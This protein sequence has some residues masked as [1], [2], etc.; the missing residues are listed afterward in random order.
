VADQP[1][2]TISNV[3]TIAIGGVD[4]TNQLA[5]RVGACWVELGVNLPAAFHLTLRDANHL[6]TT[7]FPMIRLGAKIAVYAVADQQGEDTPLMTGAITGLET[8]YDGHTSTTVVRGLDHAFK[9]L[10]HRRTVG[11]KQMSATEIVT[12]LAAQDGVELGDVDPSGI[13]YKLITQPN[14]SD[15]QF[16]NELAERSGMVADFDNWGKLRFRKVEPAAEGIS[17]GA[18]PTLLDMKV[19]VRRCRTGITAADQVSEVEVRGWDPEKKEP[20]RAT[21]TGY[22][23][24]GLDIGYTP[25]QAVTAFGLTEQVE[26][27]TPYSSYAEVTQAAA[28]L[29]SDI[30]SSF[31][32]LEILAA[33][34][35]ELVPGKAVT[36]KNAGKP[37]DGKYTV[38]TAR[39]EFSAHNSYQT[40]IT[41][42]GRQVRNLYGLAARGWAS[43]NR[44]P[45]VVNAIVDDI[46]DPA[47]QGRVKVTFP[48]FDDDYKTEWARTL[49]FGGKG[50]GGVIS[51]VVGDE[52][53]VAFDRGDMDYPYVLGG[54]YSE[55]A[56][57]PSDHD[58]DLTT[59]GHL[60]RQSLVS[61]EGHRLELL[62]APDRRASGVRLKSGDSN[63][64]VYLDES[65]NHI[66]LS[67]GK[68]GT[69]DGKEITVGGGASVTISG[70]G[71]VSIVGTSDVSISSAASISMKAPKISLEGDVNIVGALTHSGANAVFN[72]IGF[73][74]DA[75]AAVSIAGEVEVAISSLGD[76]NLKAT[77]VTSEP[78]PV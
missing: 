71:K 34:N 3:F 49:Q 68:G 10:R 64:T 70:D 44:V 56:D 61:R 13:T 53:L 55:S 4:L 60:N 54:L 73:E 48:W 15:W 27:G 40:W 47:Q 67:S 19:N 2:I 7:D 5:S 9:M 42:S 1:E 16:V 77:V 72:S 31:A 28:S 30:S 21:K 14:I 22:E 57:K 46:D 23:Y 75:L 17:I 74:V 45:G 12:Q 76:I 69:P 62:D 29:A 51:P 66:S 52:V 11:Y 43:S 25:T 78:F 50:G 20:L 65:E 6:L 36:L 26:T 37:F 33:G 39:H 35:P 8:D 18:M 24:P 59:G 32:E 63:L 41:V 58:V 38:T